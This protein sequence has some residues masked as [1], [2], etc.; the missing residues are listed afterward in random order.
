MIQLRQWL[1]RFLTIAD[2]MPGGDQRGEFG[3]QAGGHAQRCVHGLISLDDI[4][5]MLCQHG[6]RRLQNIH[7]HGIFGHEFQGRKYLGRQTLLCP[8]APPELF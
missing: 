1:N 3:Y 4:F 8:Q 6:H 7:G 5:V 2:S